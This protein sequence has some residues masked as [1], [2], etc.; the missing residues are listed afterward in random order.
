MS[1]SSRPPVRVTI[2]LSLALKTS[3]DFSFKGMHLAMEM[4]FLRNANRRASKLRGGG[5]EIQP[6]PRLPG[7]QRV[8]AIT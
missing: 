6:P 2:I 5:Q 1:T 8:Q 4:N 3:K 7:N